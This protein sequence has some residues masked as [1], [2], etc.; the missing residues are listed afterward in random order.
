ML[1]NLIGGTSVPLAAAKTAVVLGGILNVAQLIHSTTALLVAGCLFAIHFFN[2]HL[3]PE[4]FPLDVTVMTGVVSEEHLRKARP[5]YIARLE[6]EGR[7]EELI[8]VA[9]SRQRL[10]IATTAGFVIVMAGLA[11][12]A[13]MLLAYLGK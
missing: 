13:W 3:R 4:K 1:P 11:L 5:E 6:R 7:L 2:T 10:R 9:P 12:V 8:T